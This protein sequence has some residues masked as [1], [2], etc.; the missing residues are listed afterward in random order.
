MPVLDRRG[1]VSATSLALQLRNRKVDSVRS[2]PCLESER[3]RTHSDTSHT[4]WHRQAAGANGGY[5]NAETKSVGACH[6]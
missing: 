2:R 4:L 6:A 1:Q 3:R 5:V